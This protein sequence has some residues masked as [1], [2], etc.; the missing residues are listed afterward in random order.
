MGTIRQV[1]PPRNSIL[2]QM[3]GVTESSWIMVS[4]EAMISR[5][6]EGTL[7]DLKPND[8]VVV[9]GL[10]TVIRASEIEFGGP[11]P[12]VLGGG[13]GNRG[14]G[15]AAGQGRGGPVLGA[16]SGARATGTVV[17]TR[18]LVIMLPGSIRLNVAADPST[19]VTRM[20]KATLADLKTGE[21]VIATG[22][23]DNIGGIVA[24]RLD[25]GV[26]LR[27]GFGGGGGGGGRRPEGTR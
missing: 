12:V 7:A 8:T 9:S 16:E 11:P 15:G 13:G 21:S 4:P 27:G 1:D 10:P 22:Q 20:V 23:P 26:E 14:G 25:V 2:V 24:M 18:P 5:A 17:T 19:R 6:A 3:T